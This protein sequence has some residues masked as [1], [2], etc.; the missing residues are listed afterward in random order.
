MRHW[1]QLIRKSI[2]WRLRPINGNFWLTHSP[3]IFEC[4]SLIWDYRIGSFASPIHAVY[5][6]GPNNCF[7]CQ[8]RIYSNIA[9]MN[10]NRIVHRHV[11]RSRTSSMKLIYPFSEQNP[12][13][14]NKRINSINDKSNV[15]AIA[16]IAMRLEQFKFSSLSIIIYAQDISICWKSFPVNDANGVHTRCYAFDACH[17]HSHCGKHA[18]HRI[19]YVNMCCT[20][21]CSSK[22][23]TS[24]AFFIQSFTTKC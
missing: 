23:N 19:T 9:I 24:L 12:N 6:H 21:Y 1:S 10:R 22:Q 2:Y 14:V 18:H 3:N 11:R 13:V 20:R 8:L 7:Y 17:L 16:V 4:V 5:H 15:S